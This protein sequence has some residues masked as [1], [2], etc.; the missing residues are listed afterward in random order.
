MLYFL[1]VHPLPETGRGT[2]KICTMVHGLCNT[3]T[4]VGINS[5]EKHIIE[6]FGRTPDQRMRFLWPDRIFT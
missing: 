1:Y 6:Q 3:I 5:R 4:P 2:D